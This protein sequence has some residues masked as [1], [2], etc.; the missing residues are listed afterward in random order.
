MPTLLRL[1]AVELTIASFANSTE[2][3]EQL[4][5]TWNPVQ[6]SF[7]TEKSKQLFI[8]W[9]H[10]LNKS[11]YTP[12]EI[13]SRGEETACLLPEMNEIVFAVTI[14]QKLNNVNDLTLVIMTESVLVLF[15]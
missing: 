13:T 11:V 10:Q 7:V 9:I 4:E 12:L 14:V 8:E 15:F 5:F 2:N 3:L 1:T 6:I